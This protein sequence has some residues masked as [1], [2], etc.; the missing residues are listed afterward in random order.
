MSHIPL[1][2]IL[3]PSYKSNPKLLEEAIMSIL[4]QSFKNWEL[5]IIDDT[6]TLEISSSLHYYT[7]LDPRIR[8]INNGKNLGIVASLN[9][10]I[11][12]SLSRY[13]ARIDDDDLWIDPDK[14][15]NQVLFME[16]Y[17][18]Y[19]VIG[20][21]ALHSFEDGLE[22]PWMTPLT[23]IAIRKE[24]LYNCPFHHSSV[25]IRRSALNKVGNYNSEYE[26]I[27]DRELWLRI[28]KEYKLANLEH[29]STIYRH[30]NS[31]SITAKH[32]GF[33]KKIVINWKLLHLAWKYQPY[34]PNFFKALLFRLF[35][36][37]PSNFQN[38]IVQWIKSKPL[39]KKWLKIQS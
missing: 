36:C 26:G 5:I 32:Q 24:I 19:A 21:R 23:D 30:L 2:S 17:P 14:L 12:H 25:L 11:Q 1:V 35:S 28:G 31:N 38:F 8:I 10:W 18:E 13:I 33:F 29:Y 6:P 4:L 34:Y 9:N 3:L 7:T 20:T 27:E 16:Q 22:I 15:Q 37:L 39:L